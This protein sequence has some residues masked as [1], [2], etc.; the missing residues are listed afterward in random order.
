MR[1]SLLV[2]M[3]ILISA[4]FIFGI[5]I[6]PYASALNSPQKEIIPK[7]NQATLNNNQTYFSHYPSQPSYLSLSVTTDKSVYLSGETVSITVT[8]SAINTH[9]SLAAQ[10]PDGSTQSIE[11]FTFNYTRT[12]SWTA[13]ATS[14]Q[15]RLNYDGD[16]IVEA[17][18]YCTRYICTGPGLT[19][20]HWQ[21]YPCFRSFSVTG[22][23]YNYITVFS[24]DTSVSGRIMDSNQRPIP[25]ATVS[26]LSTGQSTQSDNEGY[27]LFTYKLGN[28]YTLVNEIPT[29]N[30]TITVDAVACEPQPG[31]TIQIPA[32]SG[33]SNIDFT[34]NRSFYPPDLDLSQF[35][36]SS[37]PGWTA[38]RDYVTW[39]NIAGITINS[40]VHVAKFQYGNK[41]ISPMFFD[42][43][44]KILYL[45]TAPESGRYLLD[46]QGPPDSQY[47]VAAAATVNGSYLPPITVNSAVESKGSQRLSFILQPDQIQLEVIKPFPVIGI[48]IPV[49]VIVLGGLAAAY[50]LTGGNKR[51]GKTFARL[52]P[53]R[54]TEAATTIGPATQKSISRS[55]T[56]KSNR[57]TAKNK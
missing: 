4:L 35:V 2:L 22:N 50:F 49:I 14:G 16:A 42:I 5:A 30:D 11:N 7:A 13:P 6:T 54:S 12:V 10:L 41:E 51:W 48:I 8:T 52:R 40:T 18:D 32:E 15:I 53:T 23:T 28:I 24:R 55:T 29:A 27:Y 9:V 19:D 47:T 43:G 17:W 36:Y 1:S 45:I 39:Q 26:I 37:F 34:L 21:S 44:N 46:I 25:G 3:A 31:K 33:S 38:A 20:C 56:N 57:N